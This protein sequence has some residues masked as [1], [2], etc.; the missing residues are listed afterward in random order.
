MGA[1]IPSLHRPLVRLKERQHY[2]AGPDEFVIQGQHSI[3][4]V[5]R[6]LIEECGNDKAELL[7]ILSTMGDATGA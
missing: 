4:D 1:T 7:A 2:I 5:L 6:H 3:E